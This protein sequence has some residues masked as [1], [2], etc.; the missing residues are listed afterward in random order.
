ME[1]NPNTISLRANYF[2]D[3]KSQGSY[4]K[5]VKLYFQDKEDFVCELLQNQITSTTQTSIPNKMAAV[6]KICL[7][8]QNPTWESPGRSYQI[9]DTPYPFV[10]KEKN[11]ELN[12]I[13]SGPKTE[14]KRPKLK[15]TAEELNNL[16]L[17]AT[18]INS[19]GSKS[20][21]EVKPTFKEHRL[22]H[23]FDRVLKITYCED[24]SIKA[25]IVPSNKGNEIN[26]A[27]F[28]VRNKKYDK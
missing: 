13:S 17:Q 27:L 20:I 14:T 18:I 21:V 8:T 12:K 28:S 5:N 1:M 11:L 9:D 2:H 4:V 24:F 3:N 23:L 10:C 16:K 19:N 22:N 25:E 26:P 7:N 6:I 15:V